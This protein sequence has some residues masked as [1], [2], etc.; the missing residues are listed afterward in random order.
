M[1]VQAVMKNPLTFSSTDEDEMTPGNV[2][3]DENGSRYIKCVAGAAIASGACV[4]QDGVVEAVLKR[5]FY[6][7]SVI[8]TAVI[9]DATEVVG[10]NNTGG[11]IA[12]AAYF[13]VKTGPIVTAIGGTVGALTAGAKLYPS[14]ADGELDDVAGTAG[15]A[16]QAIGMALTDCANVAATEFIALIKNV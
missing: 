4:M 11:A 7:P 5:G 14:T 9:N 3:Y 13:W 10:F 6:I 2:A 15:D 8:E 12:D 16:D 1:S